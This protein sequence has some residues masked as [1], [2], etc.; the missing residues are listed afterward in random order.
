MREF[1]RGVRRAFVAN[2][3][4]YWQPDL[5]MAHCV[6]ES[7]NAMYTGLTQRRETRRKAL[8]RELIKTAIV[9]EKKGW[10]GSVSVNN[11]RV[12]SDW[13]QRKKK[14]QRE[15]APHTFR[16]LRRCARATPFER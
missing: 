1:D 15:G 6:G 12:H 5:A 4:S 16:H 7:L 9:V 14:T 3:S 10:C 8:K 2:G 11:D 13:L